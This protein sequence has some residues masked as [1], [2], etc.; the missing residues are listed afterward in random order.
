LNIEIVVVAIAIPEVQLFYNEMQQLGIDMLFD[1]EIL[2]DSQMNPQ[3]DK[4]WSDFRL[5]M[6]QY[7]DFHIDVPLYACDE[8]GIIYDHAETCCSDC[9]AVKID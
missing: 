7:H 8:C 4:V 5:R 9:V 6:T 1:P 2:E 3:I